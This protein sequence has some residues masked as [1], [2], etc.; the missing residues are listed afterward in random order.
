[1]AQSTS[2]SVAL[3]LEDKT[4]QL[5]GSE[6]VDKYNRLSLSYRCTSQDENR[7]TYSVFDQT[8]GILVAFVPIF[9]LEFGADNSLGVIHFGPK[10]SLQMKKYLTK[11]SILAG[12]RTRKFTSRDGNEYTWQYRNS[13][14]FEW[15]CS[16][17]SGELAAYYRRGG[18]NRNPSNMLIVED[19]Y[20]DSAS[21][22]LATL[23]IMRHIVAHSL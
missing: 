15:T 20:K 3:L 5:T 19:K 8:N 21:E 7:V 12:T 13:D 23:M 17:S 4:G 6:F 2:Q 11:P 16:N 1:M 22:L 14:D 9:M 10:E 18:P